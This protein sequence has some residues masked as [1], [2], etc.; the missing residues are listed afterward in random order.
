MG[1]KSTELCG[2]APEKSTERGEIHGTQSAWRDA[3][4]A[5][6]FRLQSVVPGEHDGKWLFKGT[7]LRDRV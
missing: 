4:L 6:G 2:S 5:R 1:E 3:L 7:P